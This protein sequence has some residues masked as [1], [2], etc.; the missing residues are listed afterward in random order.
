MSS[1][2]C[3][4]TTGVTFV[5][6]VLECLVYCK[7][8]EAL[9]IEIMIVTYF[10]KQG[11]VYQSRVRVNYKHKAL[12]GPTCEQL[13]P[14]LSKGRV[15]LVYID[16]PNIL[17]T[18]QKIKASLRLIKETTRPAAAA[19]RVIQL[20]ILPVPSKNICMFSPLWSYKGM[21]LFNRKR[22]S[23]GTEGILTLANR[24]V[25]PAIF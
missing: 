2:S 19:R 11:Y 16:L 7:R 22:K 17:I 21:L 10:L 23:Q 1:V 25:V 4:L 13:S 15:N 6:Q 9:Y 5:R 3:A 12:E 20:K 24:F 18:F 14:L 8:T